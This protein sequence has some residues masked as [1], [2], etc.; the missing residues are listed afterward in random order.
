MRSGKIDS[1]AY[2]WTLVCWAQG[3]L[4]IVAS[5]NLVSNIGFGVEAT[6]TGFGDLT[7]AIPAKPM[8]FP[9]RHPAN[10]ERD[11]EADAAT[12]RLCFRRRGLF[13]RFQERLRNLIN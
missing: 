12:A 11:K 9:L 7:A 6:H 4:S 10:A 8:L 2:R 5:H 13:Q 3:W 1:W